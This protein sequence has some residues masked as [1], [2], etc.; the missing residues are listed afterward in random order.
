MSEDYRWFQDESK[1]YLN[2]RN[3]CV[4]FFYNSN[5]GNEQF[6]NKNFH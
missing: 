3:N 6:S 5:L 4:P 2:E 1:K